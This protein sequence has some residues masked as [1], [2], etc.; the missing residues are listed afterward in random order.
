MSDSLWPH[1]ILPGS[2]VH[3]ISQTRILEWVAISFSRGSSQPRD[4]TW[5]S[6]I[7][8][9]FFIIW[10]TREAPI[11]LCV[12]VCVCVCV[13]LL[14]NMCTCVHAQSLSPVR[15]LG[16]HQAPLSMEFSRWECRSGLPFP[17]TGHLPDPRI[18][19]VSL[20][21]PVL[22]GFFTTAP[23]RKPQVYKCV[24][25][26]TNTH[27]LLVLFLLNHDPDWYTEGQLAKELSQ[28]HSHS[29]LQNC[30]VQWKM[31]V[32]IPSFKSKVG[33]LFP[34]FYGL[35]GASLVAQRLK[36]SAWN[37]GDLG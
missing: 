10:A 19:P 1:E 36:A 11:F 15:L 37:A 16:P 3:G 28:S 29:Q 7:A 31:Q 8:G 35:F 20:G 26:N 24:L 32:Q 34:F 17:T 6:H 25:I 22:A 27:T 14:I 12:C 30:K 18:K 9:R 33:K 23:P 21:S 13:Y 4:W 5:V 2:S